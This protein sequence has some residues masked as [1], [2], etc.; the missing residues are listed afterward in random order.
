MQTLEDVSEKVYNS[1]FVDLFVR[2]SNDVAI[3]M[4]KRLGYTVYRR[5]LGYY[6]SG[7]AEDGFD[8]RKALPKDTTRATEKP[9]G[10]PAKP[11]EVGVK[12]RK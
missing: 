10:R 1:Y 7:P 4:Y 6:S 12:M 8:M 11:E 3:G 5:V 9:L 2:V